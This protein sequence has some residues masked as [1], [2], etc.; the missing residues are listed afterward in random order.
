[1]SEGA[2]MMSPTAAGSNLSDGAFSIAQPPVVIAY[3]AIRGLAAPLH[4]LASVLGVPTRAVHYTQGDAPDFSREAWLSV[5]DTLGLPAPN[6]PYLVDGELKITQSQTCL[7]YLARRYGAGSGIYEGSAGH[8]AKVDEMCD[9]VV[10]ARQAFTRWCYSGKPEASAFFPEQLAPLLA[11]LAALMA[12]EGGA[13][14]VGSSL[15]LADFPLAELLAGVRV[16]TSEVLGADAL[17]D[18]PLGAYLVRFESEPRV[19]KFMSSLAFMPRPF[20]NK[21]SGRVSRAL[22]PVPAPP[23]PPSPSICVITCPPPPQVAMWK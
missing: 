1:M 3:W 18:T 7:R 16:A 19:A 22:V 12:A 17:A 6:L 15:T 23:F 21:V 14:A 10:D 4:C 5:K 9:A 8:L 2:F 11:K 13:F 20:N